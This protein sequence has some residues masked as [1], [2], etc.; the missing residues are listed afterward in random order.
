MQ[1]LGDCLGSPGVASV[2]LPIDAA[3][4][5]VDSVVSGT[6]LVSVSGRL[7]ASS[8]TVVTSIDRLKWNPHKLFV[9]FGK[10]K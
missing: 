10:A 9:S 6:L 8:T 2:G 4:S 7:P 5:V 1:G 3:L